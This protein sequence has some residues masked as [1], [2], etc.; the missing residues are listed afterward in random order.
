M[1]LGFAIIGVGNI[2]P[3]HATAIRNTPDAQIVAVCTR[4]ETRGRAFVEKFGGK[5]FSDYRAVL[6][7]DDVDAIALCTPHDL[8]APMTLD[9]ARAHKHILVEKPMAR[10]VAECDAMIDAAQR[11][12][13][14][15]GVVFQMRF[16]PLTRKL[17]ALIDDG[18]LGRLIWTTTNALWFRTD[19]YYRSGAWRG[20][21]EREGGGV[22][23]NQGVHVVDLML[24]LTGMPTR[25]TA[26]T[27][28]LNHQIEVEDAALAILEY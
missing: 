4:D 1:S 24:Y 16:D 21:W 19:E 20:T 28:T 13:V 6:A 25:I 11:A 15:L 7:R 5:Y 23:I 26:Q 14:T 8:H 12:G 18:K 3:I 27:R 17:K 2:A 22:L 10:N 9:A